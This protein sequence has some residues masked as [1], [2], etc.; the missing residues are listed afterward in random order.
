MGIPHLISNQKVLIAR[1]CP[2][3]EI[4]F[5]PDTHQDT[6]QLWRKLLIC[7]HGYQRT[8]WS[9]F[10]ISE[11]ALRKEV[12]SMMHLVINWIMLT[13]ETQI[14]IL[15]IWTICQ[16]KIVIKMKS[17][18]NVNLKF[19]VQFKLRESLLQTWCNHRNTTLLHSYHWTCFSNLQKLQTCTFWLS[20]FF[21]WFHSSQSL[22]VNQLLWWG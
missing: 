1:S 6:G 13:R 4:Q 17:K 8:P 9:Q 10:K 2:H 18:G 12:A 15:K 22:L 7:S 14:L 11:K 20:P 16:R 19:S 21:K 5:H 3:S